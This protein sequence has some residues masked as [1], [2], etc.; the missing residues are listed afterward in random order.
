MPKTFTPC[1]TL[2][3]RG[4]LTLR[5]MEWRQT[6][7]T[8]FK[9]KG[10]TLSVV[11]DANNVTIGAVSHWLTGR[12]EPPIDAIRKMAELAGVAMDELFGDGSKYLVVDEDEIRLIEALRK[13]AKPDRDT[14]I[15]MLS[16]LAPPEK[17]T[18]KPPR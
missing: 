3:E 9:E 1:R 16:N 8:R 18:P 13:V 4:R 2:P 14:A 10:I 5:A 6:L 11:A 7:K 17:N 15:R 12:N